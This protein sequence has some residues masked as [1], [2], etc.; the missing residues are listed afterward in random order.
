MRL[1]EADRHVDAL[2]PQAVAFLEHVVGL[3]HARGEAQ[4][5]FQ[6]AALLPADEVEEELG[7]GLEFVGGHGL[8]P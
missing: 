2:P 3:A 7:L 8:A 4:V 5:D 6:P 1:D